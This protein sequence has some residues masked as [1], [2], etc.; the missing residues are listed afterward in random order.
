MVKTKILSFGEH[1]YG[2]YRVA[3]VMSDGR[4]IEDVIVAWGDQVVRIAGVDVASFDG[5][6]VVDAVDR[7]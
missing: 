3:L 4:L 2:A 1:S 7:S 6:E 5:S